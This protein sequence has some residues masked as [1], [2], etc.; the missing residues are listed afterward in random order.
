[1]ILEDKDACV[2]PVVEIEDVKFVE[3]LIKK[4]LLTDNILL[5]NPINFSTIK[6]VSNKDVPRL[7]EQNDSLREEK[8]QI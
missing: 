7:G 3:N 8:N 5:E 6:K 4:K 1:M 2:A